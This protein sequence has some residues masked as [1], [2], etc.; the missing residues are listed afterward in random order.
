MDPYNPFVELPEPKPEPY[1]LPW[2]VWAILALAAIAIALQGCA[3][4][5][6]HE[7]V[8]GWPNLKMTEH[9][10]PHHVMRDKCVRYAPFG[11]S[12]E[13]CAEI[14]F[15]NA[16]C[17]IYYSADFPPLK[18]FIEHERLHCDGFSH[19]GDTT[20]ADAWLAYKARR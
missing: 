5:D 7:R 16:T 9:Y 10:V 6:T 17:D 13:A 8:N 1:G 3:T 11:M 2:K 15:A 19:P 20:L 14:D 12:P 18:S 4:I